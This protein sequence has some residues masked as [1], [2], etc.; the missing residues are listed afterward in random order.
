MPVKKTD[1]IPNPFAKKEKV[2][3]SIDDQPVGVHARKNSNK[4]GEIA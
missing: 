3:V 4:Y 1:D 2:H